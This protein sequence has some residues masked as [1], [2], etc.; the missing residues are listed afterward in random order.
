MDA[1]YMVLFTVNV[2]GVRSEILDDCHYW[3][4]IVLLKSY[5][6][7]RVVMV[8]FIWLYLQLPVQPVPIT[9]KVMSSNSTHDEVYSIQHDVIKFVSDL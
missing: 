1:H 6:E 8:I 9:T 4:Y 5:E 7:N 3:I 2:S